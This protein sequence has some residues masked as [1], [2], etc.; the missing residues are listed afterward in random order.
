MIFS[1]K[2]GIGEEAT[3]ARAMLAMLKLVRVPPFPLLRFPALLSMPQPFRIQSL[4]L[5][6]YIT[7]V[8]LSSHFK[9]YPL[10]YTF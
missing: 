10:H 8:L 4:P 1:K 6:F 2:E 9:Y 3:P 7:H 5:Y